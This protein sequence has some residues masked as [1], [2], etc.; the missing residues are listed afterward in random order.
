M[1]VIRKAISTDLSALEGLQKQFHG[2]LFEDDRSDLMQA[3]SD[4][5][6]W[7]AEDAKKLIGYQL[8]ELFGSDQKNFP[9][10]IFLSELFVQP[11]YRKQGIGSRLILAALKE[12]WLSIYE[13]FSLTHDPHELHLSEYYEKFGFTESGKTHAG[14]VK[15]LRAR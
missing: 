7:A 14:N 8:C 3:I 4:G 11:E 9:N 5:H 13:Y 2:D 6:V 12:P 15:M 10:S 1:I